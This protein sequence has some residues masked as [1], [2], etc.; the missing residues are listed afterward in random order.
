[1]ATVVRDLPS[2]DHAKQQHGLCGPRKWV[3]LDDN[4]AP[5]HCGCIV[6]LR[7]PVQLRLLNPVKKKSACAEAVYIIYQGTNYI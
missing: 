3:W 5:T 7:L 1:M 6:S 4:G 2:V